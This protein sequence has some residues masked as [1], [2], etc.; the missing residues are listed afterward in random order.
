MRLPYVYSL[1]IQL[2]APELLD[3]LNVNFM[4]ISSLMEW[5]LGMETFTASPSTSTGVVI[6]KAAS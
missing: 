1:V 6:A 4:A 3:V 5:F 2:K